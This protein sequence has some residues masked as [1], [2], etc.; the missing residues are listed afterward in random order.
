MSDRNRWYLLITA[1]LLVCAL[2]P[3]SGSQASA[4][5]EEHCVVNVVSQLPDGELVLSE[6]ECYSTLDSALTAASDTT[7]VLDPGAAGGLMWTSPGAGVLF[8]TFTLGTHFDG[9]NGTGSSISVVGSSC[10][11]G[12]W[13]TSASW[14]NR[15]SSSWNGCY[16]LKHH[17]LPNRA[18]TV[19][20]TLGTGTTHNVPS[21]INDKAES[22]SYWSS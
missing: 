6:P 17:D 11:G 7:L 15:I 10:T 1:S 14:D 16:R 8:S 4:D 5:V 22:V 19:G 20:S 18:G 9:L 12:Y 21:W 3:L 2:I 13:N